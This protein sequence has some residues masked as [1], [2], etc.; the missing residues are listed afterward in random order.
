MCQARFFY[1][2]WALGFYGEENDVP[3]YANKLCDDYGLDT[4][5][6]QI[7]IDWL[8]ACF[9]AGII[10]EDSTGLPMSKIGSLEFMETL[11]RMISLREGFG[12]VLS[13]GSER[14]AEALGKDAKAQYRYADAYEPRL[15][16]TNT[17]LFPFEP[18]E[19]IQQLHEVGLTV[20]QWVSWVKGI[21]GVYMSPDVLRGIARNFWGG[22]VAADFSTSEGKVLAAKLIQDRQYVKECLM[23]CDF[24]YPMLDVRNSEDHEGDPGLESR[25]LSAVI[26]KEID[27]HALYRIGERVLNLQR[28]VLLREGHRARQDDHLPEDWYTK[29]LEWHAADPECLAPGKDGTPMSR[30]GAVVDR[31]KFEKMRDEYYQ[32]RGWD[33]ATGLQT[34][35]TLEDLELNDIAEDLDRRGLIA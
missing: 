34:R 12:D 29:P 7:M 31:Q 18:R 35:Q 10:T 30:L 23:V 17:L 3:F 1:V 16:N 2:P 32:L 6:L 13:R 33:V 8:F 4:W 14:A 26:G 22:E 19:P 21:E 15:Y 9:Q 28:A 27:E 24:K 11:V 5:D 25:I 20:A